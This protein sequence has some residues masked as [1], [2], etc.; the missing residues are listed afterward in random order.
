MLNPGKRFCLSAA[1]AGLR[2][3]QPPHILLLPTRAN[4]AKHSSLYPGVLWPVLHQHLHWRVSPSSLV[5]PALAHADLAAVHFGTV[6][7]CKLQVQDASLLL[8]PPCIVGSGCV[9][10]QIYT[11]HQHPWECQEISKPSRSRKL[12]VCSKVVQNGAG[13]CSTNTH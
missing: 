5:E 13:A 3:S 2:R 9:N 4:T 1:S 8:D 10:S 12:K 7:A 6:I 11:W